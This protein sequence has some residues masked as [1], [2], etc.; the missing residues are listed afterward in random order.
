MEDEIAAKVGQT[1]QH[2]HH[3]PQRRPDRSLRSGH[4]QSAD[5]R[6][7]SSCCR[8]KA[9]IR[10]SRSSRQCWRWS[11]TRTAAP[12]QYQ[13]AA[14]IRDGKN[15]ELARVVG[16]DEV[17]LVLADE[18]I[19]RIVVHSSRQSGLSAR[20]FRA[21][22]FRRLRNLHR[23]AAADRAA[24]ASARR[25]MAYE[26]LDADRALRPPAAVYLNPPMETLIRPGMQRHPHRRGRC[27]DQGRTAKALKSTQRRSARHG[28]SRRKPERTLMLGWNRRGP[29]IAFELS[30]YVAPGSILTIAADTPDLEAGS[31][32]RCRSP[33]TIC[34]RMRHHRHLQPRRAR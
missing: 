14:E 32:R 26:H 9:T 17:Q 7:R 34:G 29:M 2:A 27:R 5:A 19:S 23:R 10:I 28:R 18:L 15:A 1:R 24:R 31:C 12:A 20:L 13:I 8:P 4:R 16:G 21:A 25:V 6:A 11:T 33:A 22:R 30:R 3:L